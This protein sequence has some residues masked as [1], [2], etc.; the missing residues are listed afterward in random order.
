[1]RSASWLQRRKPRSADNPGERRGPVAESLEAGG[2]HSGRSGSGAQVAVFGTGL[3]RTSERAPSRLKAVVLP[4]GARRRAELTVERLRTPYQ[5]KSELRFSNRF[6]LL[7]ATILSAQTFDSR[8]NQVTGDLFQRY[9]TPLALAEANIGAVEALL[10]P[11]GF[12]RSKTRMIIATSRVLVERFGGRVPGTMEELLTLPG[13][14]RKTANAV[15]GVGFGLPSITADRHLIRLTNRLR[16]VS[17]P[18]PDEV[19][20][21][22]RT[23]VM[24]SEQTNFSIRATL[25]GRHVCVARDPLCQRCVL[26]DFCPSSC[27]KGWGPVKRHELYIASMV[28][29]PDAPPRN[30]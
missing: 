19:E 1:M 14:G 2:P 7:V 8:V 25:H 11:I 23:I 28:S 26:T 5:A 9:P 10:R 18:R 17:S 4:R 12:Y 16:L 24:P 29:A 6:Q 22:L 20:T 15:L 3:S 13:V 27:T 21:D 30:G